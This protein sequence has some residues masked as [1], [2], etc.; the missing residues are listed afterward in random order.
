MDTSDLKVCMSHLFSE[1][2]R[3]FNEWLSKKIDNVA[4][5]IHQEYCIPKDE[6]LNM[7]EINETTV[8]TCQYILTRGNNKGSMCGKKTKKGCKFCKNHIKKDKID[9]SK[10]IV[11]RKH[12]FF[13]DLFFHNETGFLV[14]NKKEGVIGKIQDGDED[15]EPKIIKLSSADIEK[16]KEL[17]LRV[18]DPDH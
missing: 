14:K 11:L 1:Q 10:K 7:F 13:K 18:K 4:E 12:I 3:I 9:A 6:I 5:K 15:E 8:L 17:G 16:C 2:E